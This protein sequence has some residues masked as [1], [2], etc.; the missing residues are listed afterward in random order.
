MVDPYETALQKLEMITNG[1]SVANMSVQTIPESPAVDWSIQ[2]DGQ[3]SASWDELVGHFADANIYQ[4]WAYGAVRWGEKNLSHLVLFRDGK[5]VAVAQLRIL[6][7]PF[8]P[9]GIAYVRGAPL[10]N[11]IE[12]TADPDVV[13]KM[14]ESLRE[15][16]CERRGLVLQVIPHAFPESGRGIRIQQGAERAGFRTDPGL[17]RYRTILVDL[18]PDADA[19]RSC[20]HHKWRYH[21]GGSEKNG[22]EVDAS[23][24]MAAY[25]EF[26]PI[27]Q[28]MVV[29]KGFDTSIDA[30]EFGR[31]QQQLPGNHKMTIFTVRK[32]G[33]ALGALVCALMGDTAIFV[34]GATNERARDLKASYI[35]HWQAMLWLKSKGARWYDLSGIDPAANPGGYQFKSGFGGSDVTQIAPVYAVRGVIGETLLRGISWLRRVRT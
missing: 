26:E 16:Y 23:E 24:S 8:L 2:V 27:Y 20:L 14:F 1:S 25:R 12:D 9:L 13:G 30:G 15:E 7:V 19:M 11:L 28:E 6:R 32:D 4:T 31:I 10:H 34:L 17:P 18:S 5:L 35:L 21:L 22:L 29:R 33:V 3:T